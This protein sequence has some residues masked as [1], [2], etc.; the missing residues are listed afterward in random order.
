MR[1]EQD[2]TQETGK[3]GDSSVEISSDSVGCELNEHGTTVC[4]WD[5][6]SMPVS[7]MGEKYGVTTE[8]QVE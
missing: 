7:S 4:D 8:E 2:Q 6:Y 1:H 3:Q 5:S